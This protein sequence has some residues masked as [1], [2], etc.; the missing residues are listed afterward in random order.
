MATT[1][2]LRGSSGR[3][4]PERLFEDLTFMNIA[5]TLTV[6]IFL[7]SCTSQH[8]HLFVHYGK[9]DES[10]ESEHV[11]FHEGVLLID[12]ENI[13]LPRGEKLGIRYSLK[14]DMAKYVVKV[15]GKVVAKKEQARPSDD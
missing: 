4:Y 6:L 5:A 11:Q 12:D 15:D 3:I 7:A 13:E 2:M 8:L 10:V 1:H 14:K 9:M